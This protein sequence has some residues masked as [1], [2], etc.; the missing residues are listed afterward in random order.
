ML[1]EITEVNKILTRTSGFLRS[2][3]SHSVQPYCGCAYGNALCGKYCYVQHNSFITRGRDWGSFLEPRS[4]ADTAYLDDCEA[5]RRWAV[6]ARG[7]FG[8]FMSSS[9]DPFQ[10]QEPT[11]KVTRDVM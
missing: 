9:T 7:R 3:S 6:N 11:Y 1:V 2:V 8:I 5:E 4:N 10:P